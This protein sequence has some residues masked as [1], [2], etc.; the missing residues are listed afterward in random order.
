MF[1]ER[2]LAKQTGQWRG[3]RPTPSKTRWAARWD[4]EKGRALAIGSLVQF[5]YS[6]FSVVAFRVHQHLS[7]RGRLQLRYT[8]M[9]CRQE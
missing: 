9:K 1:L 7:F 4:S 6:G 8:R 3:H 5:H 2:Q